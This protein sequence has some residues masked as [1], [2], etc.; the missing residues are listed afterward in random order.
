VQRKLLAEVNYL[1]QIVPHSAAW[2]TVRQMTLDVY[3]FPK[4]K[5][6]VDIIG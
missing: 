6:A 4:L 5:R 3:L 1:K 2:L